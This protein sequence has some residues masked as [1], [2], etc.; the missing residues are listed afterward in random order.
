MK[1]K[2]RRTLYWSLFFCI[3]SCLYLCLRCC[4]SVSLPNFRWIQIYI[5]VMS[6]KTV[7]PPTEVNN[8]TTGR[9][10]NFVLL[11][12]IVS[13]HLTR[14]DVVSFFCFFCF[15]LLVAI[16]ANRDVYITFY[17]NNNCNRRLN[18]LPKV[19]K[20]WTK[21]CQFGVGV[22]KR[23]VLCVA[24]PL[25]AGS[26]NASTGKR[27]GVFPSRPCNDSRTRLTSSDVTRR[28]P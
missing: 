16:Y 26:G 19:S 10:Y 13:M 11:L 18:R 3:V 20:I 2:Q 5:N 1:Q 27:R 17:C 23:Q 9:Q 15:L 14:C 12:F 22:K 25:T 7:F 6:V 28:M 8:R 4:V 21:Y 24:D